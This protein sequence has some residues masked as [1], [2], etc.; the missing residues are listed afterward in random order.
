MP[1]P[2]KDCIDVLT[3]AVRDLKH[4]KEDNEE[5]FR[6]LLHDHMDYLIKINN[7]DIKSASQLYS[8]LTLAVI[9]N[10]LDVM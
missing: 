9:E 2:K 3:F 7:K 1:S 10:C 4:F 5:A 8:M 6:A